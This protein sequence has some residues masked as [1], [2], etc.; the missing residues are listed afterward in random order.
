MMNLLLYLMAR[1][2]SSGC[3]STIIFSLKYHYKKI[4]NTHYLKKILFRNMYKMH[5]S[6][7]NC[8]YE[9]YHCF[10]GADKVAIFV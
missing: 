10:S 5:Y 2:S 4:T 7:N 8:D 9:I 6:I 3:C 1:F